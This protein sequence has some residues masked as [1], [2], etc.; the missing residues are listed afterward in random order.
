[1]AHNSIMLFCFL[2]KN[3][4]HNL[5]LRIKYIR[6]FLKVLV[7]AGEN[8]LIFSMRS[9]LY[10]GILVSAVTFM[11]WNRLPVM[12]IFNRKVNK[13]LSWNPFTHPLPSP[14]TQ[15]K[16]EWQ[17]LWSGSEMLSKRKLYGLLMLLVWI[18]QPIN[19]ISYL[20]ADKVHFF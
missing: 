12:V 14:L 20:T 19:Q 5:I 6:N 1:M 9:V 3:H 16:E 18:S 15:K 17:L 10:Y 2:S 7:N 4:W 13:A 11:R 8:F